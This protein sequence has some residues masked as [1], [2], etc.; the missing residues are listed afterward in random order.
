MKAHYFYLWEFIFEG[1][2][3]L[4]IYFQIEETLQNM[5]RALEFPNF[6]CL[7]IFSLCFTWSSLGCAAVFHHFL[8]FTLCDYFMHCGK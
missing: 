1:H 8:L 5:A 4:R 2:Q 6:L 7:L 3:Y